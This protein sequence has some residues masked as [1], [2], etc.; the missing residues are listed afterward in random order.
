MGNCIETKRRSF[1]ARKYGVN[2][3]FDREEPMFSL[4][5]RSESDVNYRSGKVEQSLPR[6]KDISPIFIDSEDTAN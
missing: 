1:V 5:K 3:S 6:K 4:I 2:R